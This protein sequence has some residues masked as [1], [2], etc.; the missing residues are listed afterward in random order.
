MFIVFNT[1][2]GDGNIEISRR[3]CSCCDAVQFNSQL[4]VT[5]TTARPGSSAQ[6]PGKW[7]R[8]SPGDDK[9]RMTTTHLMTGRLS[10]QGHWENG[11]DATGRHCEVQIFFFLWLSKALSFKLISV[12]YI[13]VPRVACPFLAGLAWG[14]RNNWLWRRMIWLATQSQSNQSF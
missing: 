6:W 3:R 8:G 1:A 10:R 11:S 5:M 9:L 13:L 14:T 4:T 7:I 12:I 2:D